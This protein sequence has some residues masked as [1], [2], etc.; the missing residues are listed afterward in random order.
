[1]PNLIRGLLKVD[2]IEKILQDQIKLCNNEREGEEDH[3]R[4]KKGE[5]VKCL[6]EKRRDGGS[7][8]KPMAEK[9]TAGKIR[10][11]EKK[12]RKKITSGG[13]NRNLKYPEEEE[14]E[15]EEEDEEVE[16]ETLN[17]GISRVGGEENI[18]FQYI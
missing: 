14:R 10:L 5:G 8:I 12:K 1:M 4:R 6:R 18:N 17:A 2:T 7:F 9:E 16:E 11:E 15:E 3:I 13:R